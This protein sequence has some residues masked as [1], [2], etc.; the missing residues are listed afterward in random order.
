MMALRARRFCWHGW[1]STL[2]SRHQ[3]QKGT[4]NIP[5]V[6]TN[7]KRGENLLLV[8]PPPYQDLL[9]GGIFPALVRAG[10]LRGVATLI[11]SSSLRLHCRVQLAER[12]SPIR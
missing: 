6:S 4:E 9:P 5:L 1:P 12:A 8:A 10:G 2:G 11:R 3:S 7:R